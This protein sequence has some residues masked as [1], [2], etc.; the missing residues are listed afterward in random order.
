IPFMLVPKRAQQ[1]TVFQPGPSAAATYTGNRTIERCAPTIVSEV[2]SDRFAKWSGGASLVSI[3]A[4]MSGVL[5]RHKVDDSG[6]AGDHIKR[7]KRRRR[8]QVRQPEHAASP[9]RLERASMHR[10]SEADAYR[11]RVERT[12]HLDGFEACRCHEVRQTRS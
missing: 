8:R 12:G 3:M 6:G 11:C 2:K 9:Y 7:V 4:P 10:C 5:H 1:I